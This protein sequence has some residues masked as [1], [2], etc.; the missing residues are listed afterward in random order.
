MVLA[1]MIGGVIYGVDG[2]AT[3]DTVQH[4]LKYAD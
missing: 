3:F 4:Q 2:N 1:T